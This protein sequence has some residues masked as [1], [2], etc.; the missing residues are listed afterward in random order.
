MFFQ[1]VTLESAFARIWV[2][3]GFIAGTLLPVSLLFQGLVC[4]RRYL[5]ANRVLHTTRLPVPVVVVGNI[6][7]GGTGKTP[8]TIWL[9]ESLRKAGYIPGVISR[10]YGVQK[11]DAPQSV[12][13][14]SMPHEVGDEPVL[15]A[16]RAQCPV[17]VSRHRVAAA[18]A[19]LAAYPEVNVIVSDDGLQHYALERDVEIVLCDARGE[20]NGWL[21]PA[22]PLREPV[23][24]RRDFT[25]MNIAQLPPMAPNALYQMTLSGE[26]AERMSERSERIRLHSISADMLAGN[27]A[28]LRIIAAAGI[29]NPERFFSLLRKAGIAFKEMPLTDHYDFRDNPFEK[30]QADMILVTEKDAVKCIQNNAIRNDARIWVVPVSAF[31]DSVLAEQIVEKCR[32]RP[33]A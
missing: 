31:I 11:S 8:F 22:G 7:V 16:A 19:L 12:T 4:L 10:G 2:R 5:Y 30:V 18:E 21:L 13:V 3:R 20:G 23:S 9:V 32:G 27:K 6:F 15:I 24:R 1:R 26:M 29:G 28:P 25:V 14:D 17:M 33:T